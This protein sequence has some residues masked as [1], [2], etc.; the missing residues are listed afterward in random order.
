VGSFVSQSSGLTAS[1]RASFVAR[2]VAKSSQEDFSC[3][4]FSIL[5]SESGSMLL[6]AMVG[7]LLVAALSGFAMS[8]LDLQKLRVLIQ[9][10]A[11]TRDAIATVLNGYI[12][13]NVILHASLYN[14]SCVAA[15]LAKVNPD[16]NRTD[17]SCLV[18]NGSLNQFLPI[19]LKSPFDPGN[20]AE[21]L[22]GTSSNPVLY[23]VYGEKCQ[24]R[25]ES[26]TYEVFTEFTTNGV[27]FVEDG[28]AKPAAR[29]RYKVQN[30]GAGGGGNAA[31]NG[32][33]GIVYAYQGE[34][35]VPLEK[36]N[37]RSNPQEFPPCKDS[38]GSI[39]QLG[40]VQLGIKRTV[41]GSWPG[42]E[43]PVCVPALGSRVCP[44]NRFQV[45]MTANGDPI[46]RGEKRVCPVGRVQMGYEVSPDGGIRPWCVLSDCRSTSNNRFG[47]L[48]P[49]SSDN[50]NTGFNCIEVKPRTGCE[51]RLKTTISDTGDL[52]C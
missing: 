43:E 35:I 11:G 15:E 51:S 49:K 38:S 21:N 4:R 44:G 47:F 17:S 7:V 13:N 48:S 27:T 39:T 19:A 41:S 20:P 42:Y 25:S 32:S 52:G 34:A 10:K 37:G 5:K 22:T 31:D 1:S 40:S 33:R 29:I 45:G 36:F 14:S 9:N 26:C 16:L 6:Q 2:L 8:M 50:L 23:S 30:Q 24:T 18:A 46:C 28:I 3:S 12:S